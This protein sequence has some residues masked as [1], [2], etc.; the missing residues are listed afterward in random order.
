MDKR[1]IDQHEA[2]MLIKHEAETHE[3]PASK[4]AYER[5]ARIVDQMR[6]ENIAIMEWIP[7]TKRPL[8]EEEEK[9]YPEFCCIYMFDGPVPD[10]DL[11]IL[12]TDGHSMWIDVFQVDEGYLW[13]GGTEMDGMAWMRLTKPYEG[14]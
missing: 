8:T 10:D 3:L 1:Y 6:P 7:F 13:Y 12:V 5:A 9:M 2:Y 4:E 11:E 14:E